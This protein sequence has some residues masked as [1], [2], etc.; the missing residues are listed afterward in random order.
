MK[1]GHSLRR[2]VCGVLL[3]L[4]AAPFVGVP[5]VPTVVAVPPAAA[6]GNDAPGNPAAFQ[7]LTAAFTIRAPCWTT[8]G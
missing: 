1:A 6:D 4:L 5:L 7:A 3:A 2:G 8:V